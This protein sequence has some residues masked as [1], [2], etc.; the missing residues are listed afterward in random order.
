MST[1]RKTVCCTVCLFLDGLCLAA[2]GFELDTQGFLLMVLSNYLI[3][4]VFVRLV[5]KPKHTPKEF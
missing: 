5:R 2:K 3:Y 1:A 4:A